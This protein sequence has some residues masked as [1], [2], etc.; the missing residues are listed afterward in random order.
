LICQPFG[1]GKYCITSGTTSSEYPNNNFFG[2]CRTKRRTIAICAAAAAGAAAAYCAYTW[3]Y[4]TSQPDQQTLDN[5]GNQ[6]GKDG[7]PIEGGRLK[8]ESQKEVEAL[9]HGETEPPVL[10]Q[11]KEIQ[12]NL[13]ELDAQAHMQ[14]HF[15]SIQQIAIAT[16]IP[17]LLP[18]LHRSLSMA[19][20]VDIS[21]ERLMMAKNGGVVLSMEEKQILWEKLTVLSLARFIA[22]SWLIPL[23]SLQIRVQLS[24]LGRY[25]YLDSALQDAEAIDLLRAKNYHYHLT[26]SSQESFLSYAEHLT[27]SGHL[28]LLKTAQDAASFSLSTLSL[29]TRLNHVELSDLLSRSFD[30]FFSQMSSLGGLI[31]FLLPS[32]SELRE[33]LRVQQPNNRALLRGAEDCLVDIDAVQSMLD[34]LSSVLSSKQ[35]AEVSLFVAKT[36][37]QRLVEGVLSKLRKDP[38]GV[39]L[40][41]VVPMLVAQA[42]EAFDPEGDLLNTTL[43]IPEATSF[44]ALVYS[45]GV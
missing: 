28:A 11:P 41:R 45:S 27:R 44:C 17:S 23:F 32:P 13:Q 37:S 14:Q 25:L 18:A 35:F 10:W 39:P 15:H 3:Y 40:A 6:I 20:D 42:K 24:I 33:S 30:A 19:D 4:A 31:T 21:L 9:E 5:K 26:A 8:E 29:D 12:G 38:A 16:T 43:S 22:T 7:Q 34:E 36:T 2:Q 1:K